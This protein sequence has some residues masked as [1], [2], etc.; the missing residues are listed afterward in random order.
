MPSSPE[1]GDF[2]H[3]GTCR[4]MALLVFLAVVLV[5]SPVRPEVTRVECTT[6]RALRLVRFEDG[7]ARLECG[8]RAL[9]RVSVPG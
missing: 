2:S 6:P 1:G 5:L 4:D 3:D 8:N 9:V 7:S